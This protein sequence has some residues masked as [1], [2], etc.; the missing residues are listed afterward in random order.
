MVTAISVGQATITV[1]TDDGNKTATCTVTVSAAGAQ[2]TTVLG[3]NQTYTRGSGLPLELT[4]KRNTEDQKTFGRFRHLL[5]DGALV[6]ENHYTKRGQPDR[7]AEVGLAGY[8]VC[9]F[10]CAEICL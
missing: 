10:T 6:P 4:I 3:N 5:K 1:K 7:P 2:Y 8:P 9:W